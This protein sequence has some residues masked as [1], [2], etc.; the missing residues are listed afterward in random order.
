[1]D[2]IYKCACLNCK[3][4]GKTDKFKPVEFKSGLKGYVCCDECLEQ[5]N[6]GKSFYECLYYVVKIY[7]Y[8]RFNVSKSLNTFIRNQLNKFD[9]I[10]LLERILAENWRY[11]S[12]YIEQKEFHNGTVL[13]KYVFTMITTKFDNEKASMEKIS[14]NTP[15]EQNTIGIE[16]LVKSNV[17]K[18]KKNISAF[19]D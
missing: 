4:D 19:L 13:G 5:V 15:R 11:I 10:E 8:S 17:S 1:M 14:T 3:L 9:D 6:Q 2:K 12:D 18:N 16:T 7:N